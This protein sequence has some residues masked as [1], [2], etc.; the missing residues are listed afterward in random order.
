[1]SDLASTKL[2]ESGY[3]ANLLYQACGGCFI[4]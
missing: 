3:V 4:P 2:R 1:M